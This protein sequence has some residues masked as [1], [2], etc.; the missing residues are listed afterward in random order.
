M[1]VPSPYSAGGKATLSFRKGDDD[2]SEFF[3][4]PA[5]TTAL[6]DLGVRRLTSQS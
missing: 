1:A 3:V 5:R 6:I 2:F 4:D